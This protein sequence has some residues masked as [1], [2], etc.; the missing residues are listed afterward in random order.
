MTR[1]LWRLRVGARLAVGFGLVLGLL[2]VVASF[3]YSAASGERSAAQ[4]ALRAQQSV[5]AVAAARYDARSIALQANSV[6]YD[7][8]SSSDPADDLSSLADAASAFTAHTQKIATFPLTDGQRGNLQT[9]QAAEAEYLGQVAAFEK[10]F[11]A[12]TAASLARARVG[13]AGLHS[14]KIADPL[15]ALAASLQ[16]DARATIQAAESDA[17]ATQ[18]RLVVLAVGALLAALALGW[19]ISRS[20][21]GPLRRTVDVLQ[22]LAAGDLTRRLQVESRDEVGQMAAALDTALD[23]VRGT[24]ASVADSAT[25]LRTAAEGVTASAR[26]ISGAAADSSAQSDAVS[27]SA[28]E[29]STSV[30]TVAAG[31]EQ[32]GASIREIASNASEAARVAADAVAAAQGTTATVTR[33]GVSSAEIGQVIKVITGIAEQTNLLALNATI[34]AARAGE[35]G[36]GFAVVANEVKDL[37]QATA[38]AT[39]DI[40]RRVQ[41]IQADTREAVTA[42]DEITTVIDHIND[43]QATIASAVEE[44]SATTTEMSRSV[45]EAADGAER[46]ASTITAVASAAQVTSGAA[47]DASTG[48]AQVAALAEQ[49]QASVS[50]FRY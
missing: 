49:L 4:A 10:D 23:R 15:A 47:Q 40:A 27:T 39:E 5:E 43:Y 36:K 30:T 18:T 12:G 25:V 46:I 45:A 28:A 19:V 50:T 2:A 21:T 44:Q 35:A 8:A 41:T 38:R 42:I 11:R 16:A 32:M 48:A 17:A 13:V 14:G 31:A 37:A 24:V 33:L 3:G 1:L 9:A 34:E 7:F 20:I 29:V 22:S 6:A 26:G